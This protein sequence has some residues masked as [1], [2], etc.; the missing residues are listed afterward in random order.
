MS[1]EQLAALQ[2]RLEPGQ[3][4]RP[5]AVELVV[6]ALTQLVVDDGEL[7]CEF[8]ARAENDPEIP[9]P[10]L[11]LLDLNLPK[12]SGKEVLH[13]VRQSNKCKDVPVLIITSSDLS[14]D[15][16]ELEILGA[17]RYF[18]KPSSYEQFLKI[19]EILKDILKEKAN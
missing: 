5:A 10:D 1:G 3:D 15:R 6:R 12:R 7:A 4:H 19:G 11:L 13:C 16:D 14:K 2:P 17:N 8:V 9:C 18:R